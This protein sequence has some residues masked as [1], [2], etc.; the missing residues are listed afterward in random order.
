MNVLNNFKT[1]TL[2]QILLVIAKR[3]QDIFGDVQMVTRF[4][5]I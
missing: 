1:V 2:Q 5:N 4:L 3:V